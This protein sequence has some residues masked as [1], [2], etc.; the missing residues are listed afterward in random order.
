MT[1]MP[2]RVIPVGRLQALDYMRLTAALSVLSFHYFFNGV[3]NGKIASLDEPSPVAQVAKYGHLGVN[4]FFLISGFIIF[5][6]AHGKTPREFAVGRAVR[7][8]PAF[9]AAVIVTST[10][11]AVWGARSHLGVDPVQV[12]ANFTM[13][14]RLFGEQPVDGVYWT[15]QLEIIFYVAVYMFLCAGRMNFFSKLL[16]LWAL[17]TAAGVLISVPDSTP[18]LGGYFALFAA[19][20]IIA[21]IQRDGWTPWRASGLIAGYTASAVTATRHVHQLT[22]QLGAP[23]NDGLVAVLVLLLFG[24]L[25]LLAVPAVREV[26]LPAAVMLGALTYPLYLIHA[27][28]GYIALTYAATPRTQAV[29]YCGIVAAVGVVAWTIHRLIERRPRSAWFKGFDA[30]YA[31]CADLGLRVA[32]RLTGRW[33]RRPSGAHLAPPRPLDAS[34]GRE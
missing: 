23:F 14:P 10:V 28:V 7:L 4:W 17:A 27:H 20:A 8:Y 11:T 26:R 3:L 34:T 2:P 33:G 16:P 19:G 1:E 31:V 6:S 30:A 25:L 18:L 21:E 32:R 24:S 22:G 13:V 12:L 9:W 15:L 5:Q 29:A